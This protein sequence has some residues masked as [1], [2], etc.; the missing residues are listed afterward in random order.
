MNNDC[1]FSS[2][3][4]LK[5]ILEEIRETIKDKRYSG[6]T[7]ELLASELG[8]SREQLSRL[9]NGEYA[10]RSDYLIYLIVRL[11]LN[12]TYF[13]RQVFYLLPCDV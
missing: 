13:N 3:N 1:Y 2:D 9:L 10:M 5:M 4:L 6:I 7:Q 12:K 11:G 8:I